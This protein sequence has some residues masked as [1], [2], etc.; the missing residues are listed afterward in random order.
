METILKFHGD[1]VVHAS[2]GTGKTRLLVE[3]FLYEL[4]TE[5]EGRFPGIENIVAITFTE[6]AADEMS[7]RISGRIFEITADMAAE[8]MDAAATRLYRHLV[9][10]RRRMARAYVSTIH[11]FCARVL[12]ENPVEAG[13]DPLFEILDERRSRSLMDGALRQFLMLKLRR[14]DAAV[15]DLAY[16]YG[17]VGTGNHNSSLASL[18]ADLLPLVRASGMAHAAL[19]A[20][21]AGFIPEHRAHLNRRVAAVRRD[22]SVAAGHAAKQEAKDMVARAEALMGDMEAALDADPEEALRLAVSIPAGINAGKIKKASDELKRVKETFEEIEDS[23]AGA[24]SHRQAEG[25][26]TLL[27]EFRRHYQTGVKNR[28]WLDFDD[29]E[30]MTI[31]LFKHNPGIRSAYQQKFRKVLVDEFQDVNHIQKELIYL[32]AAPGEGRLVVVGDPKQA[33]YGFRGGDVQVFAETKKEILACGGGLF[34]L[35][36]NQRAVKELVDFT[37]EVLLRAQPALFSADDECGAALSAAGAP[38]VEFFANVNP[39]SADENRYR[40]A[41]R[42]ASR[43][44][45]M[46]A[47]GTARYRDI[48]ILFR[49]FTALPLYE[50]VFRSYGIPLAVHKGAGFYQSQEVKDLI[51]LLAFIEDAGDAVSWAAAL[52]STATSSP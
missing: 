28:G 14:R 51:S 36:T 37:N 4:T 25:L 1:T 45:E 52:R 48:A 49:K 8:P 6:K 13:I 29:L 20:P 9:A 26:A 22:L 30:E 12:R 2:A 39:A 15:M 3:K 34:F 35:K 33:I 44:R 42:I 18:V 17:F 24:L 41:R 19:L 23:I 31:S 11:S 10:S 38:A 16:R 21:Y 7:H 43:I 5:T 46:A 40:E 50:S 47:D 27:E 32:L